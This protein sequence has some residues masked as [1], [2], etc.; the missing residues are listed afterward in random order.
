MGWLEQQNNVVWNFQAFSFM[1]QPVI[2][3]ENVEGV[4]ITG[5]KLI[6]KLLITF[7][8]NVR[9]LPK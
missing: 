7:S 5:S 9:K 2:N 1:K 8:I 3:L 4:G 6:Q